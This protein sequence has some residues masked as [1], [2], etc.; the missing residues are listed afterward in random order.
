MGPLQ[1]LGPL[2]SDARSRRNEAFTETLERQDRV[3]IYTQ[4]TCEM[5]DH[6]VTAT[7]TVTLRSE[8]EAHNHQIHH[9]A[10]KEVDHH[11]HRQIAQG[12]INGVQDISRRESDR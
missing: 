4:T 11:V 10:G 1:A 12:D 3:T 8:Q 6:L 9:V 5:G 7:G 2:S